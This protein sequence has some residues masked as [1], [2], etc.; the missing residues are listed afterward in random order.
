MKDINTTNLQIF[1]EENLLVLKSLSKN[2][3]NDGDLGNK[4]R[5]LYRIDNLVKYLPNDRELGLEIRKFLINLS[6]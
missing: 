5:D 2:Y 4:V 1:N 6:K 3:S